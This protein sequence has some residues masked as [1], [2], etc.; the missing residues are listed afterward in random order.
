[1]ALTKAQKKAIRWLG[2]THVYVRSALSDL[3]TSEIALPAHTADFD[4]MEATLE[5]LAADIIALVE[6]IE[7][8]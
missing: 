7:V 3:Q 4:V 1:M 6:T 8:E 2:Q 5:A